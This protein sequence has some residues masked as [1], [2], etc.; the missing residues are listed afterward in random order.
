MEVMGEKLGPVLWQFMQTKRFDPD[1]FAA[2]LRL[3]PEKSRRPPTAPL[4]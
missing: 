1:D 4:R 2:F 3:L